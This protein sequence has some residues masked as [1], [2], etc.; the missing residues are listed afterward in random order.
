MHKK[1]KGKKMSE[2]LKLFNRYASKYRFK[3]EQVFGLLKKDFGFNRF[4]YLG[5]QKVQAESTLISIAFNLRRAS[6]M[7]S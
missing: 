2:F 6:F 5:L 7:I 4:R 3:I 1:P